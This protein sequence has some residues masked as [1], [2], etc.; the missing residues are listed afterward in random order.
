MCGIL[1]IYQKKLTATATSADVFSKALQTLQLRGPDAQQQVSIHNHI[2]GHA[3]LSIIDTSN[4]ANQPFWDATQNHCIVFNGEIFN[5]KQLYTKYLE[6]FGIQLNTTSDTEVLLQL[7]IKYGTEAIQ[8][9]HGFFAFA[10]LQKDTNQ[11]TLV[12]DRFGKKPLHIFEN[13]DTIIFGSELKALYALGVSKKINFTAAYQYF[14]FN[15][16][17][18]PQSIIE[19]V[20]KLPPASFLKAQQQQVSVHFYY[21]LQCTNT[22]Y[23]LP[24][25][26][27]CKLLEIV[28]DKA[29]QKR[30]VSDV[31]L[32]S[33]LSGG[34]DSSVVV[35]LASRHTKHLN[36]FSIGYA[37]FPLFDET[38]YAQ[39]VSKKYNTNHTVFSLK[40]KDFFENI[41]DVLNYL[42]EPF[43]D[44]S[45]IPIYILSKLT[46]KHVTVAL[47]GDGGDEVFS[48]YNKHAA[49]W[50]ARN[51]KVIN[52]L[53]AIAKPGVQLLPQNRGGKITNFFRKLNKYTN[54]A[55]L[56]NADRYWTWAAFN[57]PATI[58]NFLSSTTRQKVNNAELQAAKEF[59]TNN[60]GN[61]NFNE[62]L[63]ADMN[64]VLAGDMLVKVDLMSMANSIEV[65]S[66]FLDHDVVDF[67]FG[68]PTQYKI[69]KHLKKKIVQETFKPLLPIELFNRPKQ[70]FEIP[71]NDFFRNEF[72][73]TINDDLLSKQFVEAQGIFN[74]IAIAEIKNTLKNG[75]TQD[76]SWLVW[77]LVVFQNWWKKYQIEM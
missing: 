8:W 20:K 74:Y 61:N 45:S 58:D 22:H 65:R 55:S 75:G 11:L 30:L 24:Y 48:G 3:R 32:G 18:Q 23:Q 69:D 51:S 39:L 57:Q 64:L 53:L 16:V 1:G 2:L 68:L 27:A 29:V 17:P 9:L 26:D 40:N 46:R 47:S 14:Q 5:Y 59:F 34:I 28:L 41:F 66:P 42:D 77:N 50:R 56:S 54:A 52:S 37:D 6:P 63:L 44:P 7:L 10:W 35:A 67:A 62:V 21:K 15:Y 76:V 73:S 19:Q 60:L 4:G 70:G 33:F 36:T 38:K 25:A 31:P 49:E 71:L 72:W 43:A 12:R 13:D